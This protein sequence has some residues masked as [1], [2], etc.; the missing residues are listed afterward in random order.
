[1]KLHRKD[2][3][4][5]LVTVLIMGAAVFI[6]ITFYHQHLEYIWPRWMMVQSPSYDHLNTVGMSRY[7]TADDVRKIL[8]AQPEWGV[9]IIRTR[10]W[11]PEDMHML[12]ALVPSG[13][14][15][16]REAEMAE[17][18]WQWEGGS[19]QRLTA[20]DLVLRREGYRTLFEWAPD[21][22]T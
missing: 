2:I 17:L 21:R 22:A 8:L 19:I 10:G 15:N 18:L 9:K 7:C 14:L 12:I 5:L 16:G 4:M 11:R 1:M 20:E 13:S 3:I 6:G